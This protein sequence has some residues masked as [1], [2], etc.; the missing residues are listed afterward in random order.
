MTT[1]IKVG[2]KVESTLTGLTGTVKAV[3]P[4]DGYDCLEL[5][6]YPGKEFTADNFRRQERAKH[7]AA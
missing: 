6:E 5:V 2:D 7:E 4:Q 3:I 1:T